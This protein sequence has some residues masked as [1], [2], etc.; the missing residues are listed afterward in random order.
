MELPDTPWL[1]RAIA[2]LIGQIGPET[3]QMILRAR[4]SGERWVAAVRLFLVT[5]LCTLV[6]TISPPP[7]STRLLLLLAGGLAYSA[8]LAWLAFAVTD[9]WV[10]W[11][12]S[13]ADVILTSAALLFVLVQGGADVATHARTFYE[14]YFLVIMAAG[15]RYDW[16]LCAWTG[17]LSILVY[18][19][20]IWFAAGPLG[21]EDEEHGDFAWASQTV[22]FLLL[23]LGGTIMAAVAQRAKRLRLMVGVD[24]LTG[25]SQRAPF[26]ERVDEELARAR[27]RGAPLSVTILDLDAFKAFNDAFGHPAG[28]RVLKAV[29]SRLRS[30]VR[31][32]DLVARFGGEEFVV[33][34]PET[35]VEQ[36]RQ[37]V[38]HIRAELARLR[39]PVGR[40]EQRQVT[41]SAGLASWP[42]D[43]ETFDAV[44]T[45]ADSRLYEAKRRG[46]NQVVAPD[47]PFIDTPP[48]IE[49]P[50]G[51]A[52]APVR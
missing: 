50:P 1:R 30:S 45:R 16:R 38:E 42:A 23:A 11:V 28:D 14:L 3:D 33:A 51:T 32:S 52:P 40:G 36:A 46:K 24:H 48:S 37:R 31:K 13:A 25:L 7:D 10:S 41:V 19:L 12:S 34:F 20:L 5:G 17:A 43:G 18:A 26:I 39:I 49:P 15:L 4:A 8:L 35:A 47:G 27:R 44:L 9:G 21:L 29:A 22:H 6:L 2:A